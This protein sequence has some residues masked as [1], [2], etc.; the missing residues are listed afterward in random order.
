M[1]RQPERAADVIVI[2]AGVSGLEAARRLVRRGLEVIVLE[3]R[4]RAGGRI[5]TH[6]LPA[7]PAP[8]EAGAE[9]VHGRPRELLRSLAA[10]R[11]AV[12]EV[13]GRRTVVKRGSVHGA[14]ADWRD[15][16]AWL[17]RLPDEDVAFAAMIERPEFA[18]RIPAATRAL[19]RGFVEGFNAADATRISVLGLNR[20]TRASEAEGS[21]AFRVREGYD[22]LVSHLARPVTRAGGGLR[23]GTV[24]TQVRWGARGVEV[25]ARGPLGGALAPLRARAALVTVPLGV[26]QARPPAPGAVEFVP[27]LPRGKRSAIERLAMGNVVKL[28][29]LSRTPFGVGGAAA[30]PRE[31]G[32][33]HAP[34]A[35]V[36]TWWSFG[37]EPRRCLVGWVA[38]PAADR[39]ASR[40]AA[41]RA[42]EAWVATAVASL[43]RALGGAGGPD[44]LLGA[45]EDARVFDWARDPYARG[46]YSWV[47][48]GGVDAPAALGAPVGRC[49]FFAGE[50][51]DTRGDPGTVHGALATG[52]RA[53]AEIAGHLQAR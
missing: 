36:P 6:H 38:G 30:I 3:A 31:A 17:D 15:A 52:A 39:F 49:L 35:I 1:T 32:F 7:W 27:P 34:G 12:V 44:A 14:G 19:L 47:P 8:V 5:D 23:L 33:I 25:R 41:E 43:A 50:A 24:V 26:L 4:P 46:A 20:Q 11:A 22:A 13:G 28:A 42:S 37:P 51:T 48:V 2:G 21:G 53:A 40:H 10:A 16:Q 29:L 18:R 9:F 45:V